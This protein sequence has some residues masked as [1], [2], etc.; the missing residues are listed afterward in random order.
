MLRLFSTLAVSSLAIVISS[1]VAAAAGSEALAKLCDS[2]WQGQL[3]ASPTWATQLGDK[4]YD[5]R[6]DDNTPAGIAKDQK[7]LEGVL[8]A[9]NAIDPGPLSETDRLTRTA[10]MSSVQGQLDAISCHFEDW[11]VDPLGGPQVGFMSLAD[12]TRIDTPRDGADLRQ[13]RDARW[14]STWT[15]MSPI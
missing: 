1:G 5:D 6:L 8:A 3:K 10:L 13:A 7:R 9:A 14:A 2:Y 15:T 11:V 12:Y 4:R